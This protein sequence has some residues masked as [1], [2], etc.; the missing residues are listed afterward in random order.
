MV[1]RDDVL[2]LLVPFGLGSGVL[3]PGPVA[4][5]RVGAV[6]RLDTDDLSWAV[7]ANGNGDTEAGAGSSAGFQEAAVHAGVSAPGVRRTHDGTVLAHLGGGRTVR[8]LEWVDL[9]D[10]DIALDPAAVG[11]LLG[12]LHRVPDGPWASGMPATVDPWFTRP[13][14]APAWDALIASLAEA[15]APFAPAY[16]AHRDELVAL[17]T[18]VEAP[19]RLRACHRD[20]FADNLRARGGGGLCAFDFDNAGPQDPDHELAF[21]LTE[22]ATD[23]SGAVDPVRARTLVEAYAAAGGPGRLR[24]PG[25][26]SMVIAVLGHIGQLAGERWL[27]ADDASARDDMAQW[28][29]ELTGRPLT[30][31][32][33][34]ELLDVTR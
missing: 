29:G 22:F 30:R 17:E 18:L 8:V 27:G 15:G 6:W 14:G 25:S 19:V 9:A 31:A 4:L 24:G 28:A 1:E 34:T 11:E 20:L 5:G 33:V 23:A 3:S 10:P 16:A 32:V 21:V 12:G 7:K 2:A 13:V 26:F